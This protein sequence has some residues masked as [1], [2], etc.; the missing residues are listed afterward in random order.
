MPARIYHFHANNGILFGPDGRIYFAVG[1]TTDADVETYQYAASILSVEPDGSNLRTYAVGVRNPY[2]MAFNSNGDL[3]ATE[4]G[5][6]GLAVT[7]SDELNH[8]VEGADYGF[9]RYFGL[10]PPGSG[11]MSPV[12]LFPP[13]AS[14]DGIVFYQDDQFPA[15]YFDNAFVTL[16]HFGEVY[17][18]QLT[19]DARGDYT[20]RLSVF[21]TGLL[22]PV[23]IASGPDGS[24]Y[25]ID[26]GQSVIYQI[27][28]TGG[29]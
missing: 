21:V 5:P 24:L 11:T 20:S 17:R 7:P 29:G 28:Y 26:F 15:E 14:A 19:R 6:N 16:L 8:I 9:P 25:V 4:N 2:R 3:F 13:H 22:N 12:A 23:D 27:S 18:V 1:S 10:A